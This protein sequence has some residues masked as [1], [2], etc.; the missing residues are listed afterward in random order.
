MK[1]ESE[2]E[3]LARMV[4]EGFSSMQ[5]NMN[6]RFDRVEERLDTVEKTAL[7][8]NRRIENIDRRIAT[9]VVPGT[10]SLQQ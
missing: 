4:A 8:T 10:L 5:E 7:Q 9:I 1:K 3:G 2:I 6:K